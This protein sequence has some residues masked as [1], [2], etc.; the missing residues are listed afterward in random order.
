MEGEVATK[1]AECD[2]LKRRNRHQAEQIAQLTQ[3]TRSLLSHPAFATFAEDL[4]NDPTILAQPTTTSATSST[5]STSTAKPSQQKSQAKEQQ[6]QSSSASDSQ[7]QQQQLNQQSTTTQRNSL[8]FSMLNL[9]SSHW[10]ASGTGYSF[11]QPAV[12]AVYELPRLDVL[13]ARTLSGK[14]DILTQIL[15]PVNTLPCTAM[16]KPQQPCLSRAGDVQDDAFVPILVHSAEVTTPVSATETNR[17]LDE[18]NAAFDHFD[19]QIQS[20]N[21]LLGGSTCRE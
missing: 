6:Q 5:S 4:S 14:D 16:S 18:I 11:Q 2:E 8:D 20:L 17:L 3:L 19:L 1:V 10:N 7:Q 9:G 15:S 21:M 12:M 13:P